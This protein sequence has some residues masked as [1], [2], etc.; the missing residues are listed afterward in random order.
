MKKQ[1]AILL[2]AGMLAAIPITMTTG[3]AM[4]SGKE[5]PKAYAKD[6]KIESSIKTA[7]YADPTV[8]GT[9]VGIHSLNG[10]VQLTGF[11]PNQAEKDRAAQI[12]ASTKGVQRVYN[13]ILVGSG[14]EATPTPTGR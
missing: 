8:S 10:V 3:C 11:V 13:S 7:M 5:G 2:L 9:S 14:P 6:K 12:A 1:T 4:M